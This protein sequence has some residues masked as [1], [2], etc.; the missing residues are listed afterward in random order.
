MAEEDSSKLHI[1]MFPW[2][3][4]GHMIPFLEVA[5]LIAQKGHKISFISTPRNIDRLPKLP[6]SLSS[7]IHFIK[8]PLPPV[9]NLPENAEATTDLPF[10][11]VPYLKMAF[12]GLQDPLA[13]F[14]ETSCP[15]W[16]VFDFA[17]YWLPPLAHNLGIP[18]A[19]FSIY[20]ASALAQMKPSS[21]LMAHI[22]DDRSK[23]EDLTKPP[24]WIPFPNAFAFRIFEIQRFFDAV[25]GVGNDD[26]QP[27]DI[28]RS[29]Q[30]IQHCD[31]I[32]V[33]SS[34]E[35]EPEYLDL[36][37]QLHYKPIIP[38]GQLPPVLTNYNNQDDDEASWK[39][40]K[41]WLD[42]QEGGSVVYVAFGSE[43][44]PSEEELTEIALGLELSGLPFFWVLRTR[45]G[46]ILDLPDGFED[47]TK[48]RGVVWR[49]WAPQVKILAH[50]SVGGFLSHAGWSSVVEAITFQRPLILLTFLF[51]Q[52]L[53]ARVL[54]EQKLGYVI[55]RD[56]IDGT[57]TRDSVAESVRLV[58]LEEAGQVYRDNVK[59][60]KGVFGDPEIQD[61]YVDQLLNFL[62]TNKNL[63]SHPRP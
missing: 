60:M 11:D 3:A 45:R 24:K 39:P 29:E 63:V 61:R 38:T 33:R 9:E 12:D 52:G 57:F 36:L 19:Y 51:D 59:K 62:V 22:Q 37:H 35:L 13:K 27:S 10:E 5:K 46:A 21:P 30:V 41:E 17:P 1:A 47:R 34:R 43:A 58:V 16:L 25:T 28:Y 26:S 42:K 31:A 32:F 4:F 44:D 18:N 49:S 7:S 56:D 23:P 2:L 54:E 53:N 15:D 8:L 20:T 55:P 48:G 6:P 40:I 50:E 14:L